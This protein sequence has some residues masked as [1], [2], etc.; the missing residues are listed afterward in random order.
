MLDHLRWADRLGFDSVTFSEHHGSDDGYLPSPVVAAAAAAGATEQISI[1]ISALILPLYDAVR[2][3]EDL[4]VL[5]LISGGRLQLVI[6]A[7]YRTEE[8]AMH[9]RSFA[10]R[11]EA[12]EDGVAR[13]RR[14]WSGEALI[15]D[16][17][18]YVV[19]PSPW[20]V[21][22]PPIIL[23]G[24][25]P[26]SARR[27]ARIADGYFPVDPALVDVYLQACAELGRQPGPTNAP[28]P[29]A[30]GRAPMFLHVAR[31]PDAAWRRIAP[32]AQ[33]ES[34]S[35]AAWLAADGGS[36]P[37]SGTADADVLRASGRYVVITP[38]ECVERVR[39]M[40]VLSLHP[41][42]GGLDPELAAESLDLIEHEVLP[43]L[44][45][46]D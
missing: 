19:T 14:A 45:D 16:G 13:L 33:H 30:S 36:S 20:R 18:S 46:G 10:G 26:A 39:S 4:A 27:A 5:D 15:V 31:D 17:Q 9:R 24:S 8:Y 43:A 37:Y 34:D 3:A 38:E 28:R 1:V 25:S 41:L 2:L 44:I 6:G 35:Y 7:G 12:I 32:H 11:F 21:G 29:G 40:G 42:M 22:G 23:G